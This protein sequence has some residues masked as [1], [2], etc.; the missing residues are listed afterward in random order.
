[1]TTV[2][3]ALNE[4][5]KKLNHLPY[6]HLEAQLILSE[7]LECNRTYLIAY[8]EK[9]LPPLLYQKYQRW[10]D[11]RALGKPLAY[12]TGEKEFYGL[13]FEVNES[14]LIPRDDTEIIIDAALERIP[15]NQ[16]SNL[17]DLGTGSGAIAITLKKERP[18]LSVTA[19]DYQEETLAVAKRNAKRHQLSINFLKSDWF[20]SIPNSMKFDFI[21]SNPP[22]IDPKDHLH[23]TGDG[24]KFEPLKA[25]ISDHSGYRDLFT[26][27]ES[28]PQYL[29]PSG[30]WLL[31][32]HG[33]Q[34][35]ETLRK[36]LA[37]HHYQK[38]E[39]IKDYGDNER[40]TLGFYSQ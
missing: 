1:M 37:L 28:A 25:L 17:L 4:G 27:I 14:T 31:L 34:Q 33:Y 12:L 39:T 40:V 10:I 23:L 36:K 7:I 2:E 5:I 29:A 6:P 19:I 11:A 38:I 24:L 21:L 15:S 13:L 20:Q 26:I 16:S 18:T 9:N 35:G 30:G 8:P 22:Y 3:T 32:E